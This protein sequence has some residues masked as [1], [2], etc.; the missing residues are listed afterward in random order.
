M[1]VVLLFK[2]SSQREYEST[3]RKGFEEKKGCVCVCKIKLS[4][5]ENKS[6]FFWF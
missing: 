4:I 1:E 5:Q 3:F 2:K 6:F